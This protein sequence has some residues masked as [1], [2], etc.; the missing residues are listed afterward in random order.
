M[1]SS[2][3]SRKTMPQ[4]GKRK[5][6]N[7]GRGHRRQQ[8]VDT[9]LELLLDRDKVTTGMVTKKIGI[10][11]SGFYAHFSSIEDC[12]EEAAANARNMIRKPVRD[13]I[14]QL[15]ATDP[16]DT[17]LLTVFYEDLLVRAI[18]VSPFILVFL[19]RRR[20]FTP[21][22]KILREFEADL[23][24]DLEAHLDAIGFGGRGKAHLALVARLFLSHSFVA[25]EA[26]LET[27]ASS[28]SDPHSRI[29]G[30]ALA[31]LL[32]SMNSHIGKAVEESRF[33]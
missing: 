29:D 3:R 33:V 18:D 2:A 4:T 16:A 9:T 21:A 23:E 27:G 31:R 28:L 26:W 19:R 5:R 8:I 25:I 7:R 15:Q 22:G 13:G 14:K 6:A 12:L 32:A 11:Q 24:K 30:Q 17:D 1:P 10:V 20:D